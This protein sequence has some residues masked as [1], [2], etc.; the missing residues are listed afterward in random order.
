[1]RRLIVAAVVVCAF[2][3]ACGGDDALSLGDYSGQV[4]TA[5]RETDQQVSD[6]SEPLDQIGGDQP[7]DQQ[8]EAA[9]TYLSDLVPIADGL[10]GELQGIDAPGEAAEAHHLLIEAWEALRDEGQATLDELAGATS[11]AELQDEF[12]QFRQNSSAVV[13]AACE[14]LQELADGAELAVDFGCRA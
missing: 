1:M 10:V 5:L 11:E 14:R 9:R 3:F 6:I 8:I 2:G 12:G 7:I 4:A 13:F